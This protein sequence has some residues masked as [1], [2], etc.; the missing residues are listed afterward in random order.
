MKPSFVKGEMGTVLN[1]YI[2]LEYW[3]KGCEKI[4]K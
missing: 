2:R 3:N 1:A 4:I